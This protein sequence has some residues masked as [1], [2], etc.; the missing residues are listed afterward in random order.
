MNSEQKIKPTPI[1]PI[2]IFGIIMVAVSVN[3][4]NNYV[5]SGV[6]IGCLIATSMIH[7]KNKKYFGM[8]YKKDPKP[9]KEAIEKFKKNRYGLSSL[10]KIIVN[11][12]TISGLVVG[13]LFASILGAVLIG[14]GLG[15]L[16]LS[17]YLFINKNHISKAIGIFLLG[18]VLTGIGVWI[19]YF[20]LMGAIEEVTDNNMKK[21]EAWCSNSE[22]NVDRYTQYSVEFDK[23]TKSFVCNCLT[24][25]KEVLAQT[26]LPFK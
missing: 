6:F 24:D 16:S 4:E 25:S 10:Q 7:N 20:F 11:V 8:N 26:H 14:F 1:W 21:C 5:E 17:I 15:A 12:L 3:A 9:T 2:W 23:T 18:I 22:I 13:F 19:S